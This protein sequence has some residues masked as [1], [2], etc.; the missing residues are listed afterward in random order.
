MKDW[1]GVDLDGT[2]AFYEKWGRWDEIGKPIPLMVTRVRNWLSNGE[3]VK[4]FTAR[5]GLK[6]GKCLV[7]GKPFTREEVAT[8][9]QD[10][11]STHVAMGWRPEVTATKDYMMTQLWDDRAIQ[12][13]PNTGRTL[14]DEMAAQ[15][16]ARHG[17]AWKPN[18]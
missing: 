9:I 12:V 8:V 11:C 4:I 17:V 16:F 13:V 10:W 1:I 18:G 14:S 15:Y 6:D 5:V 7:T 3:T 2:L